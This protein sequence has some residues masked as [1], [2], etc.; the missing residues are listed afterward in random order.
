MNAIPPGFTKPSKGDVV[1][2]PGLKP[3]QGRG[4]M[5]C[6]QKASN[7]GPSA[8]RGE[9][10]HGH[11]QGGALLHPKS[12]RDTVDARTAVAWMNGHH[13]PPALPKLRNSRMGGSLG[14]QPRAEDVNGRN[15]PQGGNDI[16]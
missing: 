6:H 4:L 2:S 7:L 13:T 16:W 8:L 5:G 3:H 12:N 15:G 14:V 10:Q 9:E 1:L 11:F